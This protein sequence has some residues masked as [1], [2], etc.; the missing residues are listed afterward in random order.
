VGD[1]PYQLVSLPDFFGPSTVNL[2]IHPSNTP[3][4]P[5]NPLAAHH[6][7]QAA[8]A[9]IVSSHR[10]SLLTLFQ[11]VKMPSFLSL[12]VNC[13]APSFQKKRLQ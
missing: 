7:A 8:M 6:S 2:V 9:T 11:D 12:M 3:P 1:L 4:L 10:N 13:S 5:T